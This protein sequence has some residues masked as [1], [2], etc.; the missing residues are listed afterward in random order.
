MDIH[1]TRL[2]TRFTISEEEEQVI[3]GLAD[4]EEEHGPDRTIVRAMQEQKESRILLSGLTGRH[5]GLRNGTRQITEL[6]IPGDPIDVHSFT[7]KRL[8][9]DI[10]SFSRCRLARIPHERLWDMTDRHPRLAL[11]YWFGTNLDAAI[12]REWELSLGRRQALGRMAHL[13]CETR[14]RMDAVGLADGHSFEFPLNQNELGEC[15][16]LTA[17]HVNRTLQQLRERE[18]CDLRDGRVVI[19]DLGALQAL[20]EFDPGYLYLGPQQL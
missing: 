2:R 19:A 11:I 18:L 3:R 1:L 10:V 20:A 17:V 14:E 13:F 6:N 4:G 16:G 12:H 9:H 15:L 5:K 8:D 7:L